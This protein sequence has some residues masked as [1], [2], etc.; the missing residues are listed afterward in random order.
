MAMNLQISNTAANAAVAAL[1]A[2]ANGGSIAIYTGTQPANANTGLSGNTLLAQLALSATAFSVTNNVATANTITSATASEQR[3][4][5]LVPCLQIGRSNGGLRWHR[6]HFR[7]R[8]QPQLHCDIVRCHRGGV[9]ADLHL[10]RSRI[11][12]P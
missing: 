5:N 3:H 6:G 2:L 8:S 1:A 4:G 10:E 11:V 9:G 12:R 7:V